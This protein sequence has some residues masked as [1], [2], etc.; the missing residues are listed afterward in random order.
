MF[1][2]AHYLLSFKNDVGQIFVDAAGKRFSQQS[3][4]LLGLRL[5]QQ[6]HGLVELGDDL[7]FLVHIAA[8][9]VSN[10][11]LVCPEAAANF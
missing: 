9:D 5:P 10:V 7:F 3:N 11:V 8:A 4:N 1:R 2:A 6:G